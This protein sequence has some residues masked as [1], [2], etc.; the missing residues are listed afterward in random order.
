MHASPR[1][2]HKLL[3]LLLILS[4]LFSACS[5]PDVGPTEIASPATPTPIPQTLPPTIVETVPL[6]GSQIGTQEEIVFYFNQ[7][8]DRVS[9]EGAWNADP[10]VGGDFVWADD[11]T[12]AFRPDQPVEAG[13]SL[14]FGLG[15]GA[16]ASNG[17]A[18]EES[19]SYA[20]N[21]ADSLRP[22]QV[23]PQ[24]GSVDL[25]VDSAVVV[26]FNQPVVPLGA[27]GDSL[28]A[29][30][31]LAPAAEGRG[32]WLNT[33]T[34]I[35]YPEPPLAG[36]VT[37][38]ALL[39]ADLVSVAGTRLAQGEGTTIS[40]SFTTG[41]PRL[42]EI[43]PSTEIPLPLDLELGLIF[44]QPMDA[45]SV[46]S[47]L[48][49]LGP[50]GAVEGEYEWSEDARS[51]T[52]IVDRILAR[53]SSYRFV[54]NGA[55][56]AQGGT[57]LGKD[58]DMTLISSPDFDVESTKPEKGGVTAERGGGRL[59]FTTNVEEKNIEDYLSLSPEI[60]GFE[61]YVYQNQLSFSGSFAHE[62]NYTLTVSPGL[63]DIWGQALGQSYI[64]NFS[65]P[66]PK[67]KIA[68]PYIGAELYFSSADQ[69]T[70]YI[71]STNISSIDLTLGEVPL[72][73]FFP[74]F[75]PNSFENRRNYQP[76]NPTTL[77]QNLDIEKNKSKTI[78][79]SLA[80]G[81]QISPGFYSLRIQEVGGVNDNI[82]PS[83]LVASNVNLVFKFGTTDALVWA[84]DLGTNAPLAGEP[85]SIYDETG[86]LLASGQT[87]IDGLWRGVIPAQSDSYQDYY[88]LLG[89][90]GDENFGFSSSIWGNDISPW[91]FG[92]SVDRRPPH[93]EVYLYTDRPIYRPGQTVY[94]KAIL[95]EA[96]DGRYNAPTVTS[97][98]L[99][100]SDGWGENIHT[101]NPT[102]SAYGT[103]NGSFTIPEDGRTGYYSFH[104]QDLGFS[105]SFQV[106]DYRKPEINL[107]LTMTPEAIKS[108]DSLNAEL[109][110]RYYFDAPAGDLPV[111]WA[112]YE[113][114]SYF[115]LPGYRVGELNFGWLRGY[116]DD[117]FGY[118][119]DRIADGEGLTNADG[120]LSLDLD[121]LDIPEGT[122]E[123]TLEITAQDESGQQISA[124]ASALVHPEEFYVG[125][126]SDL[127]VGREETEMGFD[128]L[129]VD[130]NGDPSA[131]HSLHADFQQI[132][133]ERQESD[134]AY[135]PPI[136]IPVY[137]PVSNVDLVTGSDGIARL[138]FTPPEPGT[139]ILDVGGENAS[140]QI[141]LWV[142]GAEQ[143]VWP[144]LPHQHIRLTADRD[145]YKP[146]DTAQIFIPNP[147][148]APTYALVSVER[149]T[150]HTS[151]IIGI[152]PGGTT[153]RLPLSDE[154]A[155]TVYFSAVLLSGNNFRV[156]YVELEIAPD[157]QL[158]NVSLTSQ[159]SRSEPGGDVSFGI[160]VTDA[161]GSPVQGEFSLAVVDL[162]ALALADPNSLP[163]ETA[164]YEKSSLGI[165]TNL[166]MSGDSVYGIFLEQGGLGGGG[167][168]E[169]IS[170]V[171][172]NFPDTAYWNAEV[173]TDAN[174][175]AQV[176]VVLPD[177][178][179]TWHVDLR[180]VT[181][182]TL[183][184]S[185]EMQVVSTK[186][187]LIRPVTP[188]FMVVG[189]HVEMAAIVHNNTAA[190]LTGTVTLQAIGFLLD[191]P[192]M[193]EQEISVPAGGRTKVSWWG[194]AQDSAVAELLFNSEFGS[195]QDI[196]RPI[197]GSLPILRYTSP[198]SFVTAGTLE[199]AGSKTEAISL[200][201][202]FIPTGGKLEVELS[203]SLSAAILDS[204]EAIPVPPS[205]A[206]NEEI[207]S[208]LL[209][210]I[211]TYQ[212]LQTAGLDDPELK[213]RLEAS[214]DEG[215]RH[216]L[217]RQN[218]DH[219]WGW[220]ATSTN[221]NDGIGVQAS[222]SIGG[223]GRKGDPY[224][225]AYIL[226]GLWQAR[227]AG[228]YID[229]TVF[230]NAREY[231]HVASLPIIGSASTE[232]WEKGRLAFYQYVMQMTG[233]ADAVAVDQL[234]LWREELSPWAQALLALTLESRTPGDT[235]ARSLLANLEASALR[236][237]SGAH[238]ESDSTSW[239]NPGTPNYTTATVIY[240]LAQQD[241]A[242][243]LL[244]DAVRYLSAHRNIHGY[245]NSTYENSWS[246]LALT[247]VMKGAGELNA[248]FDFSADLNGASI[249]AGQANA[250]VPVTA[251]T[252]LD[253]L[254]LALP[255]ALNITRAEGVG[256]LYYRA[257]LFAD[258]AAETAPA[259]NQGM[260]ISRVYT[261]FDCEEE[262]PPLSTAQ[263]IP[264]AK[265]KVQLTLNL[266][267]D[268]YYVMV[269][270]A[271]P[272]G[273]EILNQRLKTAQLGEPS[274]STEL[275]D[276]ENPFA[277]GW[278]WWLFS[279]PQI[280]DERIEWAA[281]Y[282]PAGTYVLSYTLI[283]LQ[284][285]EYR[286]LPAHAWQSYFPEVQGTSAGEVFRIRE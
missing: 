73:D 17:L 2:I 82:T 151:E 152:E 228:T 126:R 118:F 211:E 235:R 88:A 144:N 230:V 45:A 101:L 165:R 261:D 137:T 33:S 16:K 166:S 106:A 203:P 136:Y 224:L 121:D 78:A 120:I 139:Y 29:A 133:W 283:P 28:P 284:A 234:D 286:V 280:G 84:S 187:V 212:A 129:T 31:S 14:K 221:F 125:L 256:R 199:E 142:A 198:Q 208:Y 64:Y 22:V 259:L 130:W 131:D 37:Y 18:L 233:G 285:G 194:T 214:L 160:L 42:L 38:H 85:V 159:P 105:T 50:A 75:G 247:E 260:E 74:L 281:D 97:L 225:S 15:T 197:W 43:T 207:L 171:R 196:T 218:E 237:A 51:V 11:A 191:D 271:F 63:K 116:Y 277:N 4:L 108:G 190:A 70:F 146:G 243:P 52:F 103:A 72:V 122:R 90:P 164:F 39:N 109:T 270:D 278:G 100:I 178:L 176:S 193:I 30:F 96:F 26:S 59:Y 12:V 239:R 251:S 111:Q 179:T 227:E 268:S 215:V 56:Q 49:L 81:G 48:S 24:D 114:G 112:L 170:V 205:Y 117:G 140:T 182:D 123:L 223:G 115:R 27:D 9:V 262:C 46:E 188:R 272:A 158:L 254:Q 153:Y 157:A 231:I 67:P 257:A 19:L 201:R 124:R 135:D 40:W 20:F 102:L 141:L 25:S 86:T 258:R 274:E 134:N 236:S 226:F 232:T 275:Y 132:A 32:E 177:N 154:D 250:L 244:Q 213:Q 79:L 267:E 71:Q 192:E 222:P 113:N 61:A 143:A 180:G 252:L 265:L 89:Q 189:D 253:G 7:P 77:R 110:A 10:A 23:L 282:L 248:S 68:M 210:N 92:L 44:N 183:V 219:G 53:N 173:L 94:F 156:G 104:N 98:P 83:Y 60:S 242:N 241:P 229:E 263:L 91:Q 69:P 200:P 216:L 161:Q 1:P 255:N 195:Y 264:G 99:T 36:G 3:F 175:Q 34:Y 127:W 266:P 35:F 55:A 163:I 80:N 220:Y 202:S 273:T 95:R 93:T 54:L 186:D 66:A 238:W 181:K 217:S 169:D 269:E 76:K 174:G 184:G 204:L 21:V 150:I 65:T 41:K 47:N 147:L 8:M 87:D 62:E 245:W 167:G 172:D 13:A 279:D 162:A 209:P 58:W 138:S 155:P 206:S 168:G 149:G 246:L 6:S 185:A 240:A 119:G 5:M 249:S 107:E 148:E 128:V 276:P 57:S 145:S